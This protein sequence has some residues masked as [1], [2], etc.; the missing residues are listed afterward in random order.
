MDGI[1]FSSVQHFST[2]RFLGGGHIIA[3]LS[4][5][6][7]IRYPLAMDGLALHTVPAFGMVLKTF[8]ETWKTGFEMHC[9]INDRYKGG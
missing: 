8:V 6:Y 7:I 4:F 1:F 5:L 3:S 2:D 9:N